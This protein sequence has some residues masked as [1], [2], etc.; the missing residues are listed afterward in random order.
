MKAF[1]HHNIVFGP[2][3]SRRLG[4][5]LGINLLPEDYKL[6]NFNCIYCECGWTYK[7]EIKHIKRKFRTTEEVAKALEYR[8]DEL[9]RNKVRIDSITFAGCG[10]PTIHPD[11]HQIIDLT[12]SLRNKHYPEARIS[13]LS[14]AT[15]LHNKK[16]F[17]AL[18]KVDRNIQK[19]DSAIAET[20]IAINNPLKKLTPDEIIKNLKKFNGKV[21]IQ[22]LFLRGYY[23]SKYIDNTTSHELEAWLNALK[24]IRP[25]Q[26]M[27]Y[28]IDRRTPA[29]NL[30]KIPPAELYAIAGK[31]KNLGI[32]V[33]VAP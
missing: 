25:Q 10:E 18:K 1:L 6:C 9:K 12:V 14:N 16:V 17:D 30:E 11:F 24:Q 20:F 8:L 33:I 29:E 31:V 28:T 15:M 23:K 13:V 32:D 2:V 3:K 22:T 27:V 7:D 26:V 4:N 21:I 19:L 5:S